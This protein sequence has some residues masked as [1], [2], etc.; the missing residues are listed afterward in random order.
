[1]RKA[2]QIAIVLLTLFVRSAVSQEPPSVIADGTWESLTLRVY[3]SV[4]AINSGTLEMYGGY[5]ADR[6]SIDATSRIAVYAVSD[7]FQRSSEPSGSGGAYG[8][9][10]G[11]QFGS[12]TLRSAPD[13]LEI[14]S[15]YYGALPWGTGGDRGK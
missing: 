4:A 5:K 2:P 15:D 14:S 1:M 6:I 8:G 9:R 12:A 10:G 7:S 11:G 13:S 3:S